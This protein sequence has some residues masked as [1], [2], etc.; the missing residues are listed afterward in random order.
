MFT[1]CD[2]VLYYSH[3]LTYVSSNVAIAASFSLARMPQGQ[4]KLTLITKF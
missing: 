3:Q 2:I 4:E 1:F